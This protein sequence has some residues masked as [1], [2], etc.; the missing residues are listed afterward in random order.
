M[1]VGTGAD[2]AGPAEFALLHGGGQGGWVWAETAAA[3]VAAGA[4]VLVLDIPGCGTKRDRD[5][6]A[7]G[8][9]DV[10][11][12]LL[13]DIA[14]AGMTEPVLVGHSQAGTLLPVL[15][16][17]GAFRKLI[18]LSCCAPLPGQSVLDMLGQG[19][20]GDDPG[21]VGWPREIEGL[22]RD[23]QQRHL[24]CNDMDDRQAGDF[25]ARLGRDN[26]PMAVN[27]WADWSYDDLVNVPSTYLLCARDALFPPEWQRRFAGRLHAG[28]IVE[29]DAG[30][31]AMNTQPQ[32]L[33]ELL[34][35]EAED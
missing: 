4:R 26:W 14:A 5:T 29:I 32:R 16:R 18:H 28:R 3:L 35:I 7:L 13:R 2:R 27:L 24:F 21:E 8:V 34:L 1:D 15:Q 30:H 19:R 25:I 31:Q 17:R 20:R 33:A 10:A 9:D 22:G 12:E 11:D 23:E 6:I